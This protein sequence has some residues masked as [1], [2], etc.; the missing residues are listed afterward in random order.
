[1]TA[2]ICINWYA[3]TFVICFKGKAEFHE[4]SIVHG[5]YCCCFPTSCNTL[6]GRKCCRNHIGSCKKWYQDYLVPAIQF[7]SS[8]F[9]KFDQ[10]FGHK[11]HQCFDSSGMSCYHILFPLTFWNI[12]TVR[13]VFST[14]SIIFFLSNL[15][16]TFCFTTNDN[17]WFD[18]RRYHF[19]LNE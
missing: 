4:S 13:Y 11:A 5:S 10:F 9:C 16:Y 14:Q 6:Y 12:H 17:I 15:R 3:E 19:D 18:I 8:I 2:Q 1:M 7:R